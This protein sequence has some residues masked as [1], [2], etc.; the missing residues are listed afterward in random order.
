MPVT[1]RIHNGKKQWRYRCYYTTLDGTR[2]Q[3][4]SK[5][6]DSKKEAKEAEALFQ[7]SSKPTSTI[8]FQEAYL[9][10]VSLH[11]SNNK[12]TTTKEKKYF[13]DKFYK[14]LFDKKIADIKPNDI[15][16]ILYSSEV[17]RYSTEY[18]NRIYN[19]LKACFNH[20]MSFY[21][22]PRNPMNS[23]PP[24]KKTDKERLKEMQIWTPEQFETFYNAFTPEQSD[25]ANYFHIL[26]WTG[27]RKN[28]ARSLQFKDF[29]GK[30]LHVQRQ[31]DR[32][33]DIS[34]LK[35]KG[36]K[37]FVALDKRSVRLIYE[38]MDKYKDMDG[39]TS[40]WF[41]FGGY[42]PL[43]RTSIDRYKSIVL[44]KVNVP[45]IRTHDLRHSHASYLIEQGVNIYKIS[46]R[47]GHS[48][49]TITL[50]R[51]GHLMDHEE[52]EIIQAI[53]KDR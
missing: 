1:S 35:T 48:S 28:E 43:S 22:L 34:V 41:I 47:L 7:V 50:D 33:G 19:T 6:Y 5:W 16:K 23:I 3:K 10:Y 12:I 37:R 53:E 46:K 44:K 49:I 4:C 18:K 8:T 36:S 15:K 45:P 2:K 39:F 21:E 13:M 52:N 14:T 30:S 32:N 51:Y 20:C 27:L 11:Q 17:S 24:F 42:Q 26:F 25:Y 9:D 29:D 38:Q 31:I 40:E